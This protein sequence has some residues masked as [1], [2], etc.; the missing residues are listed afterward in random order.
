MQE[1][2]GSS[3]EDQFLHV[4]A[5]IGITLC[6][7][8]DPLSDFWTKNGIGHTILPSVHSLVVDV[9]LDW[10]SCGHK[11]ASSRLG[12]GV[13]ESAKVICITTE[14]AAKH[15]KVFIRVLII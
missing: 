13:V 11:Q 3:Q 2:Y 8:K 9:P 7:E 1:G 10:S 5:V 14:C 12:V 6:A 15:R 4:P